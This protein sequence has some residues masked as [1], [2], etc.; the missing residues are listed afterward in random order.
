MFVVHQWITASSFLQRVLS[1]SQSKVQPL[2]AP[3]PLP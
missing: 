1:G 2:L 3:P